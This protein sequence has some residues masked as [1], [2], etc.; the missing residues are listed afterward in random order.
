MSF[1]NFS[2]DLKKTQKTKKIK[3]NQ[4]QWVLEKAIL[5][6]KGIEQLEDHQNK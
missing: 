5:N 3:K 4:Q 2:I 1:Y 6:Y